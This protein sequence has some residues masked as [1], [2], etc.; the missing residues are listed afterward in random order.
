MHIQ[1]RSGTRYVYDMY[2]N[3]IAIVEEVGCD[4]G[5]AKRFV[6][7]EQLAPVYSMPGLDTFTLELT[8][9]CNFRCIY[10]CYSGSYRHTRTHE[11]VSMNRETIHSAFQFIDTYRNPAKPLS[12]NFYG[13]EPLL[14]FDLLLYAIEQAEARWSG[15]VTFQVSTNGSLLSDRYV[16]KLMEHQV[17]LNISLDGDRLTHDRSRKRIN[18]QG[19]YQCIHDNLSAIK[20]K[21][22]G[23]FDKQIHLLVTLPADAD[24]CNIAE[25]WQRSELLHDKPPFSIS[26]IA[27]NYLV[28]VERVKSDTHMDELY[29][30]I[31]FRQLHP[32]NLFIC[33]YLEE[34]LSDWTERL[35]FDLR[36]ENPLQIC[37]PN[38]RS[39]FIDALG[40]IGVCEKMCDTFRIGSLTQ[41]IDWRQ[42]NQ[43]ATSMADIRRQ[44]CS[45]CEVIRLCD[46]CPTSLDL[47]E[48]EMDLECANK[49]EMIRINFLLFCE[50]AEAGI[51]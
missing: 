16:D 32:D 18:G 34:R 9:Q 41:G 38:N 49:R 22:P 15:E 37:L 7:F 31:S 46:T 21:N 17:T 20:Q 36:E 26:G 45:G 2:S 40:Q 13:G 33:T 28:G 47:S 3:R 5:K 35:I 23:Y 6:Q 11:S 39:C 1:T 43:Q 44:R 51:I 42:V 29:K 27:P 24:I 14:E 50:M 25:E 30:I 12:L 4:D 48:K 19:T 8:R 10:C